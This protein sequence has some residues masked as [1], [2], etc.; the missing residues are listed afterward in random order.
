M[1]PVLFAAGVLLFGICA[2]DM[3]GILVRMLGGDYPIL[4]IAAFQPFWRAAGLVFALACTTAIQ[5][6]HVAQPSGLAYY[7]YSVGIGGNRS[8]LFL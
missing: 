7:R 5:F 1:N 6:G 8:V 3:M 4:Q 2:F